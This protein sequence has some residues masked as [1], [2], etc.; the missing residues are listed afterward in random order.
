M[1]TLQDIKMENEKIIHFVCTND[2]YNSYDLLI[3]TDLVTDLS[4]CDI[5]AIFEYTLHRMLE[6]NFTNQEI[7]Y[8][9]NME[10]IDILELLD[11]NENI[12]IDLDFCIFGAILN[13][14]E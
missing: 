9:S 6:N 7:K 5:S 8:N 11:E 2:Y 14:F 1:K 4:R 12:Y 10:K 3:D 13:I